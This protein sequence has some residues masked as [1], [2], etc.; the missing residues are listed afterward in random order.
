[1]MFA[2][3]HNF[4]NVKFWHRI[5]QRIGCP[6]SQVE[7]FRMTADAD[8]DLMDADLVDPV[9]NLCDA[10]LGPYDVDFLDAT[11]CR[12]LAGWI[13]ARL[14]QP[15]TPRLAEIYRKLDDYAR[16]AIEYNTGV[17]IEL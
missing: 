1:M 14:T 10:L 4:D 15:I 17:V 7:I 9:N 12:L 5:P 11:Q 2:L 8:R 16:R 6:P 3:F 13:E